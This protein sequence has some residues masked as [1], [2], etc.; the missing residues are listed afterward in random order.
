[1]SNLIKVNT[2]TDLKNIIIHE[3]DDVFFC[4]DTN[5]YYKWNE[6]EYT[7]VKL[8]MNSNIKIPMEDIIS[9]MEP[10]KPE[11]LEVIKDFLNKWAADYSKKT[12][13]MLLGNP[14]EDNNYYT[15]FNPVDKT[16]TEE[17]FGEAVLSCIS[18]LGELN[19]LEGKEPNLIFW[20]KD[21]ET[22]DLKAYYLFDYTEGVVNFYV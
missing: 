11:D 8:E 9:Q 21:K 13:F 6:N 15:I 4:E 10:Y 20:V 7:E 19:F 2:Y 16:E 1:M 12:F 14:C 18:Y 22:K 3:D 5:K 17:S